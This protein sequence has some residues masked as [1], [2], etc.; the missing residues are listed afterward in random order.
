MKRK[1]EQGS[2][3][4]Q[5]EVQELALEEMLRSTFIYDMI[6]EVAKGVRGADA[7][8]TVRNNTGHDCGKILYESKRTKAFS[9]QWIDKLK[10][11]LIGQQADIA[12]IVTETMPKD[13]LHFGQRD[14]VWICSY[15]EVKG[16]SFVLRESLIKISVAMQSQENKGDKMVMLYNYLTSNEFALQITAI[17]EGFEAMKDSITKERT[18]MEKLWKEREKQ[19]EKVLINTMG[20]YGSVKGIAGSAVPDIKLIE[21]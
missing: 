2:M 10:N 11:D 17:K 18:A 4:T 19:L 12:V 1:S 6:E 7:I 16:L 14:G 13:M 9:N 8:Q 21:D 15:Q 5:G 20:F 3:Q